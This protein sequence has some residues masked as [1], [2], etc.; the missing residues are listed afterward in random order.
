MEAE[1]VAMISRLLV[2]KYQVPEE[3]VRPQS[4]YSELDVDSLTLLEISISIERVFGLTIPEGT[5][6][7]GQSIEE[8]ARA[9]LQVA[10]R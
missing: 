2:D 10:A 9:M 8:S 1:L 7:Y 4:K 3:Q 6:Q 5:A